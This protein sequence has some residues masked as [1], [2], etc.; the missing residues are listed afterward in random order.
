LRS[1]VSVILGILML[2]IL[3][4]MA[5]ATPQSPSASATTV[6][7]DAVNGNNVTGNGSA[8]SPWRTITKA[9][10]HVAP[11]DTIRVLPGTYDAA[12]GEMF[13][14]ALRS[15]LTLIGSGYESTI[16]SA[17]GAA[18]GIDLSSSTED[19]INVVVS[20][21]TVQGGGYGIAMYSTA[22]HRVAATLANLRIRQN[23]DGIHITT[24]NVY[25]DGATISPVIT[26]TQVIS[27]SSVGIYTRAYGYFAPSHVTPLIVNTVIR[28]NGSHG[29]QVESSATG[30]NG[31]ENSPHIVNT[32]ITNNHGHGIYVPCT[33]EGWARPHVEGS[34]I[35]DNG[36]WGFYYQ[37]G[38]NSGNLSAELVNSVIAR[39]EGG[40]F[41]L[42]NQ[43]WYH[44][45]SLLVTNSTLLDN[46][47]YGIKWLRGPNEVNPR[48]VNSIVWNPN[49]DDLYS[50]GAAWSTT[51]VRYSDIEDGDLNSLVGNFS[52]YPLLRADGYHLVSC[53][54]LIDAGT[55]QG[56]P[57][58]DIDGEPRPLGGAPD[59]GADEFQSPCLL[60]VA[61]K[62]SATEIQFGQSVSYT[63]T[64]SNT[65]ASLP[66]A[67][68]L[69]DII[70]AAL[71]YVPGSAWATQGS[72]NYGAG[73]LTWLG[74]I[75]PKAV[76]TM[77]FQGRGRQ[78]SPLAENIAWA[79]A[80]SNGF[81]RSLATKTAVTM[82][83]FGK[84][85]PANGVNHQPAGP[86]LSWGASA[87][88]TEYEY[89]IDTTDNDNCDS[90]W[91][92]TSS[93]TAKPA[94]DMGATYYWQVR[95]HNGPAIKEA[96]NGTWWSFTVG[97][98]KTH[99][100]TLS[101][102]CPTL[103]AD[104]FSDP[105]SGWPIIDT[106][107]YAMGYLN[108]EYRMAVN[109]AGYLA[110]STRDIGAT[111]YRI[112][113][114]ARSAGPVNGSY[115]VVFSR[116]SGGFYAFEVSGGNF[117]LGRWDAG[118]SSWV[119]LIDWSSSSSI[120][121]GTQSNRLRVV[122]NS[123]GI[124]LYVND[125][126]IGYATDSVHDGTR[127]GMLAEA[128]QPNYDARFDNFVVYPNSCINTPRTAP[129]QNQQA[130]TESGGMKR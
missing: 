56:A 48:I 3:P 123:P 21:L 114:D 80:G 14:L 29:I 46:K 122:R 15:G 47:Q 115:G 57:A 94:L 89:C 98:Y 38:L 110:W 72:P 1:A 6:Y 121:T 36:G 55:D 43:Q 39:N 90:G 101:N 73:R 35:S 129:T 87:G 30:M 10:T 108:G 107:G 51:E 70:P 78:V 5:Q 99:L 66:I 116:D 97:L 118:S 111:S 112:E 40:A 11:G 24:S 106:A 18:S 17:T 102:P 67:L 20:D 83:D 27:N 128:Y 41:Y 37:L 45:S 25:Q 64:L 58:T 127:V 119:T 71:E 62:V 32:R 86:T 31:T 92:G 69:T 88:T 49:A 19:I 117:L 53:S 7:V 65:S 63:I 33:Y 126:M 84:V 34:W 12:I 28:G 2:V 50:S 75:A 109:D 9:L 120:H 79:D 96:D 91:V 124:S 23:G 130:A 113:V 104:D 95:T 100:P 60:N 85:S 93:T 42:D 52:A 74:S 26:N 4:G 16:I 105:A 81:Y 59:V 68:T 76:V 44:T 22:G 13:P 54:A 77:G 8:T 103:L 61:K 82:A 125:V